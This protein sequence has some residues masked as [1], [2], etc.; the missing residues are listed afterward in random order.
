MGKIYFTADMHLGHT[1]I[2]RYCGRPYTTVEEMDQALI[3]NWN[4]VVHRDDTVYVVGDFTMRPRAQDYLE[5]LKGHKILIVGNHDYFARRASRCALFDEVAPYMQIRM[6]GRRITLCHYPMLEW[7]GSR[8]SPEGKEYGYL[9]HGHIHNTVSPD[10]SILY[11]APHALN[12]GV[13]INDYRPVTFD[14]LVQNNAR[15]DRWA[16][17]ILGQD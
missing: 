14:Q 8:E 16:L 2:I 6:E 10:Y 7:Q 9:I 3:R 15:F 12:A 11:R 17:Q 1:N 5:Q 4:A 13:D